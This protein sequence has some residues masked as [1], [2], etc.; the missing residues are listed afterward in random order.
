MLIMLLQ[1]WIT[2]KISY[3]LS[4]IHLHHLAEG[5]TAPAVTYGTP[6]PLAYPQGEVKGFTP[7]H[8]IFWFFVFV[9]KNCPSS[10]SI[11]IHINVLRKCKKTVHKYH[12]NWLQL[13][14]DFVPR[15]LAQLP[16]PPHVNPLHC[17]IP[18][19]LYQSPNYQL[20]WGALTLPVSLSCH[21]PKSF[22]VTCIYTTQTEEVSYSYVMSL[23]HVLG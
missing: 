12:K 6:S 3:T 5:R 13:L 16:D 2:T 9:Q 21:L 14:G 23:L 17:K 19:T 7:F 10:A 11:L 8:W 18:G 4:G 20:V 22:A 15:L 1:K